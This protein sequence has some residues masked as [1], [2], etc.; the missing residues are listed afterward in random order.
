MIQRSVLILQKLLYNYTKELHASHIRL[1]A[2]VVWEQ[3]KLP[4]FCLSR[5]ILQSKSGIFGE[6]FNEHRRKRGVWRP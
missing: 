5:R 4:V 3:E 1:P 2:K 6:K